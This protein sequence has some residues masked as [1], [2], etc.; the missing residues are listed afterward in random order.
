MER[1]GAVVAGHICL[2]IIPR[3]PPINLQV[4]L[5]P[6]ALIE[7]GS[8]L[9]STG[10]AVSN[11][12]R[13]LHRLG[14]DT[15]LM[16]KVG[17][18][19]FGEIILELVRQDDPALAEHMIVAPGE[20]SSYTLV[21][22]PEGI[23]RFFM[24]CAGANHTFGADDVSYDLLHEARLLH[25]GYPPY[26]RRMYSDDGAQ[27][28]E[29]YRRAKE[30]GV[31]TA[32]DMALPD[33]NGP[34]G[35][36]NWPHVLACTLPYVDIFLPSLDEV[37]FMLRRTIPLPPARADSIIS[38]IG[39]DLLAMGTSIVVLKLGSRGLYL[40]T[41]PQGAP[42]LGDECWRNRELWVPCF[43]PEPLV[44][45]TGSGDATI[46]GFLAGVMRGQ[47]VEAALTSAVAVGACNVE[48]ADALSGIRS[49]DATQARIRAGWQRSSL[50]VD[51]WSWTWDNAHQAWVGPHDAR[52]S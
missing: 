42:F 8:P 27:L 22:S 39:G 16:G 45:T 18:D 15:R 9:L 48:A 28:T 3:I 11:T 47:T 4:S 20:T 33:P 21:I 41:G 5:K 7:I 37:M 36:V 12:G 24:H 19:Q 44:G 43:T 50:A 34:S 31:V 1:S 14:I 49:W 30:T 46:A 10:G 6:G 23:D 2:D 25:F 35:Q 17:D 13:T 26:M 52:Q 32:L 51:A 29:M 40:R 38:E